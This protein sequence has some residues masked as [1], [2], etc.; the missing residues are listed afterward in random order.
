MWIRGT[1]VDKGGAIRREQAALF[2]PPVLD[3]G[4]S[5][6]NLPNRDRPNDSIKEIELA[7]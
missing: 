5:L 3:A 7:P 1:D 4:D 2:L 6:C